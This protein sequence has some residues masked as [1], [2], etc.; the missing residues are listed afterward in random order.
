[1][2]GKKDEEMAKLKLELIEADKEPDPEERSRLK[3][4]LSVKT[5]RVEGELK[6]AQDDLFRFHIAKKF[7]DNYCP[8]DRFQTLIAVLMFVV[9]AVVVARIL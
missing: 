9:L 8:A 6:S 7:I 2:I 4:H 3:R 5:V 1:M